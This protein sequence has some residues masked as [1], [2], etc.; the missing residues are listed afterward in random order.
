VT[1]KRNIGNGSR[2]IPATTVIGSPITVVQM[3]DAPTDQPVEHRAGN[4]ADTRDR[5]HCPRRAVGQQ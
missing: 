3:L 2:R 1:N 5:Y 4:I